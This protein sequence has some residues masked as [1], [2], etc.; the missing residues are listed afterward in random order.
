MTVHQERR[1]PDFRGPGW[2]ESDSMIS[3]RQA[4][5][6]VASSCSMS[7]WPTSADAGRISGVQ[8]PVVV[9]RLACGPA[10]GRAQRAVESSSW[11]TR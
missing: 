10:P 2:I 9:R 3:V 11:A 4:A 1:R 6:I 5:S 7:P 8:V